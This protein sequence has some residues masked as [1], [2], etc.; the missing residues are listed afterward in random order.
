MENLR[1]GKIKEFKASHLLIEQDDGYIISLPC[2]SVATKQILVKCF[3]ASG[4][5]DKEIYYSTNIAG[6]MDG[7][8]KVEDATPELLE[9][10]EKCKSEEYELESREKKL[11]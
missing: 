8:M 4:S 3:G 6:V 9:K 10:W 7:L 5:Q 11:S 1:R 2:E